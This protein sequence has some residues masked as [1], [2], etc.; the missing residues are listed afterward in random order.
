MRVI[1][2]LLALLLALQPSAAADWY[3]TAF[4]GANWDDVISHPA[5]SDRTGFVV[6]GAVG[7]KVPAVKGLRFEAE[8]AARQNEVE[9]LGGKLNADHDTVSVMANVA[10]DFDLGG[11]L[12]PFVI[13]GL[14]WARTSA[15]FE[16]VALIRLEASGL[17][18]QLGAGINYDV[19]DGVKL[20]VGYRYFAGPALD[21]L[22]G[23]GV[24][25]LSDGSNHSVLA[26]VTFAL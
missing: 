4:G 3:A 6:G 5:V 8:L 22:A 1:I 17:A 20:G 2:G 12:T 25:E 15:T 14:G 10:Y 21:P 26:S 16:D 11:K 7:I 18:Y 19:A 24:P 13:G 23:F 9:I